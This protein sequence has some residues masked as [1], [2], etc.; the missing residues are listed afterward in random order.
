[1]ELDTGRYILRV[2][3]KFHFPSL[4]VP[5]RAPEDNV[6]KVFWFSLTAHTEL[7]NMKS[8]VSAYFVPNAP[9]GGIESTSKAILGSIGTALQMPIALFQASK[10][11]T[12]RRH[13]S[14]QDTS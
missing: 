6:G 1:M 4:L 11:R 12:R 9:Q 14:E 8:T 2:S 7:A 5:V 10:V 3:K 13:L